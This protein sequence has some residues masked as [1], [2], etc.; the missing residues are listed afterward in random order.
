MRSPVNASQLPSRATAHE[1]RV[2]SVRYSFIV[3]DFHHLLLAGL[4]AHSAL[5][6][7]ATRKRTWLIGQCRNRYYFH[8]EVGMRERS[9]PDEL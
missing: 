9:N 5:P 8:H 2:D 3:M 1:L 7:I 4:P 6:P